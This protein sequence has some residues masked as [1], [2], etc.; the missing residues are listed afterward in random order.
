[1]TPTADFRITLDGEDLSPKIRP[2]LISLRITEKRGGDADQ[3][4]LVLDDSDGRLALPPEGAVLTVALGWKAGDGVPIGLVDKG[5]FKVDEVEHSG[6][7][8][9]VSIRASAAD[10]ASA[11]TTRREQS[12]HD[13]TIGAIVQ[14]IAG[15]HKLQARCAPALA[16]IAVKAASQ[17]RESD[18]ALLRRLGREHDAVA[19]IKAGCLIF[20]PIGAGITATGKALPGVTIRRR[21]GDRHSY[22]VEK[23]EAAGK[24]V[25]E[26]HD[27]K[28]ARKKKVTAGSGDGAERKL[29]RVY[30][31]EA[32]AKRAARAEAKRAGRAPRSLN[33]T[34]ALGRA[35]LAP[36]QP[37][38][39]KGF[40]A[41]VD[42]QRWLI[43]EVSH[44]L[45][46]RA[47]FT[48]A[49]K[50]EFKQL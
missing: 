32:E 25:A 9:T 39:V 17:E 7:P 18:I 28:G 5:R 38:A 14:A 4:D 12:W 24:V 13:T 34:L 16:S 46:D 21:D 15:R 36:E 29:S 47:G 50:L 10:F 20:A 43:S 1:M 22:R 44:Q 40:K 8:D 19:T 26:W 11:L 2:R 35:D 42:A 37:A 3:L 45:D 30:A 31:S 48:T 41:D 27:R 6:P 49:M 23:R 33:L